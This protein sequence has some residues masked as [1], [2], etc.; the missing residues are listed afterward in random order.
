LFIAGN[1]LVVA[2]PV[3]TALVAAV[4]LSMVGVFMVISSIQ[5][6]LGDNVP[7]EKRGLAIAVTELG[8]SLSFILG[9]PL[10]GFLLG[11]G[12]WRAPF[13]MGA[14]LGLAAFALL[15][16]VVTNSQ[17][18]SASSVPG[19]SSLR[20][21]LA[22]PVA[23]AALG[24]SFSITIANEVVN[25]MFGVWMEDA[26]QL[27][28][29]ALGAASTVIGLS[30]LLGEGFTAVLVDRLGKQRAIRIG[31]ALNGL[32]ALSLPWLGRSLPG[33]LFGLF[34]F[35]LSFEFSIVSLLPLMTEILSEARATLLGANVAIFALGRALGAFLAPRLYLMGFQANIWTTLAFDL[36]GM[37][38]LSAVTVRE[39]RALQDAP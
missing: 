3:Y 30:E 15:G 4:C 7:Y 16:R 5:A 39:R 14:I 6:Y 22:S 34:L 8:W 29:L 9:M 10:V 19:L 35:Y 37:L 23:L 24:I 11:R 1:L 17:V 36:L 33:A 13:W 21:V 2:W 28:V 25:L 26:F 20:L 38:L 18:S 12:D 32:V 27:N 31:L